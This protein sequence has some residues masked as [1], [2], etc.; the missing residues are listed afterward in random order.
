MATAPTPTTSPKTDPAPAKPADK[1]P[2]DKGHGK[3][4]QESDQSG[5]LP[6]VGPAGKAKGTPGPAETVE[7]QGIGPRTPYPT[8]N[9]PVPEA[10]KEP[11]K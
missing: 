8:G 2:V 11:R 6:G 7:E 1:A 9:P 5:D 10:S 4:A 3:T